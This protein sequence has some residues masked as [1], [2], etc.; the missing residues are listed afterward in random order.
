MNTTNTL[1]L[2]GP[3]RTMGDIIKWAW[4]IQLARLIA[5]IPSIIGALYIIQHVLRSEKRRKR[6]F[7][8]ILLV[9]SM[10]DLVFALTSVFSS[11]ITPKE[12]KYPYPYQ[13]LAIGNWAT[14]QAFGFLGHGAILSSVLYNASLSLYY[15]LTIRDGWTDWRIHQNKMME[16]LLHAIP[17]LIG[18]G[19]AIAALSMDLYNPMFVGCGKCLPVSITIID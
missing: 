19:I 15:V 8:R 9:M 12:V 5:S 11:S 7:T 4:P 3:P 10:M 16:P 18:W 14:C 1:V 17:L 2:L 6:A 13:N